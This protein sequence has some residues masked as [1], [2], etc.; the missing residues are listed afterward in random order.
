[1][2][3]IRLDIIKYEHTMDC[4]QTSV[5]GCILMRIIY[6]NAIHQIYYIQIVTY[7]FAQRE[8]GRIIQE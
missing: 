8:H 6:T 7:E 2:T 1:M 4:E 3:Y 5:Q